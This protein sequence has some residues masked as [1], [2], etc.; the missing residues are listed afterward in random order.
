MKDVNKKR[1]RSII[2]FR[3]MVDG[4]WKK[5]DLILIISTESFAKD[6]I[7]KKY[8]ITHFFTNFLD[9]C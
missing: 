7:K 3:W 5:P 9:N 8:T 6:S 2:G 1:M 4:G